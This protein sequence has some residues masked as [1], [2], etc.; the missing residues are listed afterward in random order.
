MWYT[1]LQEL[2]LFQ[3]FIKWSE[4]RVSSTFLLSML[5]NVMKLALTV[6]LSV[7]PLTSRTPSPMGFQSAFSLN[8]CVHLV[9]LHFPQIQIRQKAI[10]KIALQ[11]SISLVWS[12]LFRYIRDVCR[13]QSCIRG[14]MYRQMVWL[15]EL[16]KKGKIGGEV[17]RGNQLYL[18][19]RNSNNYI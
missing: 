2:L 17:G 12:F 8:S 11:Y 7:K 10:P 16:E 14:D 9:Q 3:S 6:P 5:G 4:V 15:S 19:N 13:L 1:K 18:I